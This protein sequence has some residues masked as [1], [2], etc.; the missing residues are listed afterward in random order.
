MDARTTKTVGRTKVE[1]TDLSFGGSPIGN[2]LHTMT[3]EEARGLIDQ[4]WDLGI[5]YFDTAPLY[6]H[7]LSELRTG[8]GLAGRERSSFAVSTKVGRVLDPA[9]SEAIESGLWQEPAPFHAVYDYTYDGVMRSVE[10]SLE[11]LQLDRIDLL[12]MH[13][14]D[15]YTHG[16]DQ[17]ARFAQ[18]VDEGFPALV[19]LRDQGVVTA[20]GFGV[21]EADVA[22]EAVRRTDSNTLLLAGRYT[23]LEQDPLDDLL[24]LC[25]TRGVG[26][27]LG[28]VYNSGI[29]ATGVREGAKFNYAPASAE[30]SAQVRRIQDVCARH[31][32]PLP[33]AA[34]QFAAAH[35]AVSSVCVGSR[36]QAQ[37]AGTVELFDEAIPREFWNDLR[38]EGLLRDDAPTPNLEGDVS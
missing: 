36:N 23:L 6:G 25:E 34:L 13:D 10:E 37:Q 21:N 2:F 17:P 29:L 35:P 24:P 22:A 15:H 38:A 9:G 20:I 30:I 18:A 1:V 16:D 33:A 3:E 8:A 28:G 5:R 27:V 7:G 14:V 12:F 26:V 19:S 11:R 31:G 4:A 32:V